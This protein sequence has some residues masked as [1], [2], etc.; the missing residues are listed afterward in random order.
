MLANAKVRTHA[1]CR[2][3]T[4]CGDST[5]GGP[6]LPVTGMK[7]HGSKV[8]DQ[9]L[10]SESESELIGGGACVGCYRTDLLI[11]MPRES[12]LITML[13]LMVTSRDRDYTSS[14]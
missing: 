5:I 9:N 1:I 4:S 6:S 13:M 8:S 12:V 3:G 11:A 10:V 14:R 2:C 7:D